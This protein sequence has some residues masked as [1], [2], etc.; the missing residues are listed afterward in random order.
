MFTR[1]FDVKNLYGTNLFMLFATQQFIEAVILHIFLE[2]K[3]SI[4]AAFFE[5]QSPG[6][7]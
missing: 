1:L 6:K 2:W 7:C 5:K 3:T 4:V